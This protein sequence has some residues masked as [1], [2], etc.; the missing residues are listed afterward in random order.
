MLLLQLHKKTGEKCPRI[1]TKITVIPRKNTLQA[2]YF[3]VNRMQQKLQIQCSP[4]L[5]KP[6]I[7]SLHLL[8]VD[9]VVLKVE[10][11]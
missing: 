2:P 11:F 8:V 4:H 1:T 6:K 3:W 5:H 7:V 10:A 9:C